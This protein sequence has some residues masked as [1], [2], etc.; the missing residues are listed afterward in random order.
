MS[1]ADD[2]TSFRARTRDSLANVLI[3]AGEAIKKQ[4]LIEPSPLV[5]RVAAALHAANMEVHAFPIRHAKK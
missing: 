4:P 2:S 1:N 5:A 3:R